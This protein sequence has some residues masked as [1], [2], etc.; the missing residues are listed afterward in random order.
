MHNNMRRCIDINSPFCPCILA[1]TNNCVFCGQLNGKKVCDCNWAGV[2]ILYEKHWQPRKKHLR[3][4]EE[5]MIRMEA[6]TE[7]SIN[8]KINEC[9]YRIEFNLPDEFCEKLKGTGS[10]VFLR[11]PQDPQFFHFP[12]GVMKVGAQSVQVVVEAIGPKS[13][14]IFEDDNRRLLVRGPYYNGIFGQPWIDN[15]SQG[16]VLLIAGGVGQAPALPIAETL[17]VRGNKVIALLAP[18]HTGKVFIEEELKDMGIEVHI[19]PSMRRVGLPVA[20]EYFSQVDLV[21]SAGPDDQHY[22]VIDSMHSLG[23]NLP[24]AATNNAT[25]CCGEGICGSCLKETRDN[26]SIRT[27]KVQTT[28]MDLLRE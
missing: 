8:E 2:C 1:E 22:G 6:D 16:T 25:M 12:V 21:V 13:K 7:Y 14:R 26:K 23:V 5:M 3:S 27:C 4:D 11:R 15:L 9:T 17:S 24:M 19:V 20:A 10:F 18:G 28:F